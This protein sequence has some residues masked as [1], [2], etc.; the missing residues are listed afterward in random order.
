MQH[1]GRQAQHG[2]RQAQHGGRQAQHRI[3][4][5]A[6]GLLIDALTGCWLPPPPQCRQTRSSSHRVRRQRACT[7]GAVRYGGRVVSGMRDSEQEGKQAV[8]RKESRQAATLTGLSRG[9]SHLQPASRALVGAPVGMVQAIRAGA[10]TGPS[11]L[12]LSC[13]PQQSTRLL[14]RLMQVRPGRNRC[15]TAL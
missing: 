12:A 7:G 8:D 2:G 15:D 6:T 9:S 1:G 14:K 4:L 5:A 3:D 10:I 13:D 11:E